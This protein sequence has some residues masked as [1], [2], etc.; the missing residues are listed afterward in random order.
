MK[1]QA[2]DDNG[3]ESDNAQYKEF[4]NK[5]KK[6]QRDKTQN[7]QNYNSVLSLKKQVS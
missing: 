5:W 7:K 3:D 4:Q 2:I 6:R 1:S